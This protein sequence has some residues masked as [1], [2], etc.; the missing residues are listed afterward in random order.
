M[1]YFPI[2]F[3]AV[4]LALCLAAGLSAQQPGPNSSGA[5]P[6]ARNALD[7]ANLDT[8]CA[9][10]SDFYTFANGGWLKRS[11]I[12]A[13]YSSWGS[14]NEVQDKNELVVRDIIEAAVKAVH[15]GAARP[16]SNVFEIG[17][18]YEACVDPLA[19]DA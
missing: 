17:A 16:A 13:A 18:Y 15:A 11:T 5:K 9:A 8:T 14:F 19:L 1:R 4:A 3:S 2:R 10:C 7:R 6:T 12:P